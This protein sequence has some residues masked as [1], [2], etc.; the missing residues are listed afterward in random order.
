MKCHI[1]TTLVLAGLSASNANASPEAQSLYEA[2]NVNESTRAL[3][4][5]ET[6]SPFASKGFSMTQKSVAGLT[7][8]K[9]VDMLFATVNYECEVQPALFGSSGMQ[10]R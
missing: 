3:P 10:I 4:G 7:C 5:G 2:L 9:S 8:V 1:L 6:A